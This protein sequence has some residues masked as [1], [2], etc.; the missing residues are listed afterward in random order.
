[1]VERQTF[2]KV[3]VLPSKLSINIVDTFKMLDCTLFCLDLIKVG[4]IL[5]SYGY[6]RVVLSTSRVEVGHL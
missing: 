1:M 2:P 4:C 5:F 3:N 6:H